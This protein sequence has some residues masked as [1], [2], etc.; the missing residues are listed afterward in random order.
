MP[1]Q[2][3]DFIRVKY[4]GTIKESDFKLDTYDNAPVV[5]GAGYI[6]KGV[7][8][9][10]LKMNVGDK[11]TVEIAPENGFG[12]RNQKMIKLIPMSEFKKHGQKPVPGMVLNTDGVRG[13]VLS[14]TGGRVKVDFNHPLAGKVLVFDLEV[15]TKIEVPEE[16]IKAILEFYLRGE[17]RDVD[18]KSLKMDVKITDK[19]ADITMPPMM[20]SIYKNKIARE[21]MKLLDLNK[22]N[23]IESFEKPKDEIKKPEVKEEP[24]VEKVKEEAESKPEEEKK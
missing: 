16:K 7:D 6:L 1:M 20:N 11:K 15:K 5:L 3:N 22:V 14:V 21:I 10:L 4:S 13:R 19:T 8:E 18:F 2:K 24:K 9:E 12:E 17:N 23:F